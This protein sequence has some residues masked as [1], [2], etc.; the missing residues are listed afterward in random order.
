MYMYSVTWISG[1][2]W[3]QTLF[4]VQYKVAVIGILVTSNDSAINTYP[5]VDE[6]SE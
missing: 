5:K 4:S 2:A 1:I 3:I 6:N